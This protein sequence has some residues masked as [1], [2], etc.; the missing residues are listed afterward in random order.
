MYKK[1]LND[2]I[3]NS[4]RK[5]MISSLLQAYIQENH[6]IFSNWDM[7]ISHQVWL[8]AL[9]DRL[10]NHPQW[11]VLISTSEGAWWCVLF[12]K[13][14]WLYYYL[15]NGI[16]PTAQFLDWGL[17]GFDPPFSCS[18]TTFRKVVSSYDSKPCSSSFI[19]SMTDLALLDDMICTRSSRVGPCNYQSPVRIRLSE[20]NKRGICD[21]LSYRRCIKRFTCYF[22]I[23]SSTGSMIVRVWH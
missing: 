3:S 4:L 23:A 20:K 9:R 11:V 10:W 15:L 8:K 6:Y 5:L 1:L 19:T 12:S 22:Y 17:V 18:C 2:L 7:C 16:R 13:E 14:N 21:H